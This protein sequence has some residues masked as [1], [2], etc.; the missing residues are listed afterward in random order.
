MYVCVSLSPW[1]KNDMVSAKTPSPENVLPSGERRPV[2]AGRADDG[3]RSFT[4]IRRSI[5][6]LVPPV[7]YC[8]PRACP[9]F[10]PFSVVSL[11]HHL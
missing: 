11:T 6:E 4:G 2:S 7:D 8:S 9:P 10:D 1:C 5:P 3:R